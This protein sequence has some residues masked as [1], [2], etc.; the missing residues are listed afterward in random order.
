MLGDL[1]RR[2]FFLLFTSL[3]PERPEVRVSCRT[4]SSELAGLQYLSS[5]KGDFPAHYTTLE[6]LHREH[7]PLLS[8]LLSFSQGLV[9]AASAA[10]VF[11]TYRHDLSDFSHMILNLQCSL[12]MPL[13][14][15]V[16]HKR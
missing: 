14:R 5:E 9:S 16:R 12:P 13:A 11:A 6:L 7:F 15:A 1:C 2:E 10:F 3:L 8:Q 4:V